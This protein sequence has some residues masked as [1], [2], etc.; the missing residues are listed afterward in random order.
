[1]AAVRR[2]TLADQVSDEIVALIRERGLHA[3]DALPSSGEL[4]EEFGVSMSVVREAVAGLSGMGLLRRHQGREAVV[5]VPGSADLER[6]LRYR[7]E[8]VAISDLDIQAYREIVETGCA[9]LAGQHATDADIE[10]LGSGLERLRAAQTEDE[11][12]DADVN[13]HALVAQA[14]GNDL[15]VTTLGAIAPLLRRQRKRVW[16]GWVVGGGAREPV[17]E[18]HAAILDAISARDPEGAAEAMRAHLS[19]PRSGL[20]V[21]VPEEDSDDS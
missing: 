7:I 15:L 21:H 10:A 19:Q 13:F 17:I 6:L 8:N 1:M 18:A 2:A 14:A 16:R 20:D 9:R 4:A 5:A 3:G 11:L 12:H